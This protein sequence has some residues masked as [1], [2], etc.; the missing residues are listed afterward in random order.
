MLTKFDKMLAALVVSGAI[1]IVTYLTGAM[2]SADQQAAAVT[3]LTT[4][5]VWLVPNKAA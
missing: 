5:F 2:I 3:V 4:F 1:P